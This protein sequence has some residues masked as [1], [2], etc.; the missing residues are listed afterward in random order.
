MSICFQ[1]EKVNYPIQHD[2]WSNSSI[3]LLYIT[4]SLE[5][6]EAWLILFKQIVTCSYNEIVE[7]RGGIE[8]LHM[9]DHFYLILHFNTQSEELHSKSGTS[10]GK[11]TT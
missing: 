5:L 6:W 2:A 1:I 8:R 3:I 4:D 10:P 9:E 7:M 11:T